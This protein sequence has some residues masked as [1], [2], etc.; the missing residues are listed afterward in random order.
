METPTLKLFKYII[1]LLL[2]GFG[3]II[4]IQAQCVNAD[5]HTGDFTNWTGSVGTYSSTN[6]VYSPTGLTIVAGTV[7]TNT[8]TT[9]LGRQTII[10]QPLTD[11]ETKNLLIE[12][13]PGGGYSCRLGNPRTGSCDGGEAQEE[14]LSYTYLVNSTNFIFTYQYAVVLH[15]P[16]SS[17]S[18][19]TEYTMPKFSIAILDSLGKVVDTTCGVYNVYPG[20]SNAVGFTKC[21]P[22]P[23]DKCDNTTADEVLWKNWTS[24]AI[25]LSPYVGH[26]ITI[27]FSTRDCNPNG[28][29]GKHFGYAYISCTCDAFKLTQTCVGLSDMVIAP[30]GYV[31]YVWS[32]K[33]S[34]GTT[35]T[36]TTTSDTLIVNPVPNGNTI[37]CVCTSVTNCIF[38]YT[39]P[40]SITPPVFNPPA[41][42]ICLGQ[43]ATI[44]VSE[45]G[46]YNYTW[47]VPGLNGDTIHVSPTTTTTFTLT[48]TDPIGGCSA[49]KTVTIKVNPTPAGTTKSDSTNCG[50]SNGSI[51]VNLT[52]GTAPYQYLW[53][54]NQTTQQITA[55]PSGNYS[56]VVTDSNKCVQTITGTVKGSPGPSIFGTVKNET[57]AG[58]SD[59][60]ITEAVGGTVY[61]PINYL[62]S[63]SATTQNITGL[64]GGV[65][66]LTITDSVG[67]VATDTFKVGSSPIITLAITGTDEHCNH[68]D[69]SVTVIP[70]GGNGNFFYVWNN[71]ATTDSL[72]S[73]PAGT[74]SVSVTD[75]ACS[76]TTS[77]SISNIAGPTVSIP[78]STNDK[79]DA[80]IGNATALAAGGTPAYS[81]LWSP[82]GQTNA[83]LLNVHA[84]TYTVSVTDTNNCLA[85]SS[86]TLT[87]TP[88][89]SINI[90]ATIPAN[91]GYS[92]G[93]IAAAG[94][95][96]TT[97][98]IYLWN[99]SV[100]S[101]S[102]TQLSTGIYDV[103]I[104]DA[105]GCTSSSDGTVDV[106]PGPKA[107][108]TATPDIC[109]KG[110]GS[111]TVIP[112]GG[113]GAPYTFLWNNNQNNDS[114]TGLSS[115]EYS[116][117]VDDGGCSASATIYVPN[118]P[119]PTANF[120]ATPNILTVLDGPVF[121]NDIS[122]GNV[123][124]WD[125][126]LGDSTFAT[127][128]QF[129][130]FYP[131]VG[132]YPVTLIVTDNNGCKDTTVDTIKVRDVFTIYIPNC[133][134]PWGDT[135]NDWFYPQGIN[136]DPDYFEMYVFDRWGKLM[137]SSLD[138]KKDRWNGTINNSGTKD[139]IIVDVYAY[140]IRVKEL[141][142]PKHQY[143]GKI[144][145][146]R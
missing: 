79:C 72:V 94:S 19:H 64:S 77:L 122:T 81:Y 143:Y 120:I 47:N 71:S 82:S 107:T 141:Q 4:K 104:T 131:F 144:T 12:T 136:W 96:G 139:D 41:D 1:V 87:D 63:N 17:A 59:G 35:V 2:I 61:K 5:F 66:V 78:D 97:P 40:L 62:W 140:V 115:G 16:S 142:G 126:N 39:L 130:H 86:V 20:A 101:T 23:L 44:A 83:E 36:T 98:Y 116:V 10:T 34:A 54:N 138:Q 51:Q 73:I 43:T 15:D 106:L 85:T 128:P 118:I 31:S 99:N 93:S 18:S 46:N 91:C 33:N 14:Q 124:S 8:Y 109:F 25:D 22:D 45:Q 65:Y 112:S 135:L 132:E 102:N 119:G 129:P 69:G 57:C 75:N 13:P 27:N 146:L 113:H 127:G 103:T 88:V 55:I 114:I 37:T 76:A 70:S 38:T 49:S 11:P 30:P 28:S 134:T 123:V 52:T 29:A 121:F 111:A 137:F 84:A 53:N 58:Y 110:V 133:F 6:G 50:Q 92:N 90:S 80:G 7:N 108:C 125:W 100:T 68:N 56:V 145:I 26:H 48:A 105:N 117:T 89:P 60:S 74:Y 21:S 3:F 67:C 32:Y 42:T 95:G 9:D 24:V